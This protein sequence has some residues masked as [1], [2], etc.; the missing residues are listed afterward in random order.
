[1]TFGISDGMNVEM[2]VG[3]NGAMSVGMND[4]MSVAMND[5]MSDAINLLFLLLHLLVKYLLGLANLSMSHQESLALL[6][7]DPKIQEQRLEK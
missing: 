2:N 5:G 4:G 1:M 7:Q 3:M 6:H